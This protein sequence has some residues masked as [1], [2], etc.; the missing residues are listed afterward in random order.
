MK[1][2]VDDTG[3]DF[4][5]QGMEIY[6]HGASF[7]VYRGILLILCRPG[8][9]GWGFKGG[10]Y[11]QSLSYL[12]FGKWRFEFELP[13]GQR[14]PIFLLEHQASGTAGQKGPNPGPKRK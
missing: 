11:R 6:G 3:N 9:A 10:R 14:A 13:A 12:I 7:N 4:S 2:H 1:Q 8:V 5:R